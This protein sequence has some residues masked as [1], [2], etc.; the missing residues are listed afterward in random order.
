M[1][2]RGRKTHASHASKS[3]TDDYFPNHFIHVDPLS[4]LFSFLPSSCWIRTLPPQVIHSE[5][6]AA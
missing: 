3:A 1:I 4:L 6:S 5:D 2:G